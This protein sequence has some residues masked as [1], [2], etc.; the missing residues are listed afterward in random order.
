MQDVRL[1]ER[2]AKSSPSSAIHDVPAAAVDGVPN[3]VN[4]ELFPTRAMII[5]FPAD[6]ELNRRILDA[7]REVPE[8]NDSKSGRNLLLEPY[9]WVGALRDRFDQGLNSYL[10][11]TR[12]QPD[13]GFEISAYMFLNYTEVSSFTP[14]HDHIGDADI[15]AIYYAY[16]P[17][18]ATMDPSHSYYGMDEGLLV[19]HDR[20]P[21]WI[22]DYR[23]LEDADHYKI[24]PQ[25][26]RMVIH[27]ANMAHSVTPSRPCT[28][29]AVTYNCIIN[30]TSRW[31]SYSNYTLGE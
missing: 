23:R 14:W 25:A 9:E 27:P 1:S 29:I 19:L 3:V 24:Y 28:R 22:A 10:R 30:P 4:L 2:R 18:Y 6:D 5:D 26:N 21:N 7:A 8:F 12:R 31:S 11:S 16:A 13:R 17:Q 15:V 20:Q